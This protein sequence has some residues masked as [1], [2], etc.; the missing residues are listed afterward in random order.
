MRRLDL[1]DVFVASHQVYR[2]A[3]HIEVL[4]PL[5]D[6]ECGDSANPRLVRS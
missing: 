4:E 3:P 1:D 5:I 6:I 2:V